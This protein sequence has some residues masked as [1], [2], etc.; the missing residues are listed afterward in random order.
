ME[1]MFIVVCPSV[2]MR[3]SVI[4]KMISGGIGWFIKDNDPDT[5][6]ILV[7]EEGMH[8]REEMASPYSTFRYEEERGDSYRCISADRFL[9]NPEII[10]GWK[11]PEEKM[12]EVGGK[13]FSESKIKESLKAQCNWD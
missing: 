6:G 10:D 1:K 2:E 5:F 8:S 4:K 12:I 7:N 13:M 9:A 3:E 11:K